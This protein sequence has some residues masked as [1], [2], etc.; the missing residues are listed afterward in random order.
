[1]AGGNAINKPRTALKKNLNKL[2]RVKKQQHKKQ[3]K[4]GGGIRK[5]AQD[6]L[7]SSHILKKT[8]TNPKANITLSGK[9]KRLI[10]KQ[11]KKQVKEE[12][13]MDVT[14]ESK[15]K[16]NDPQKNQDFKMEMD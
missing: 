5:K 2:R 14:I 4:V 8:R 13:S 6:D 10:L 11:I 12:S 15:T 1:M 9:K 7:T 3:Q 16:G